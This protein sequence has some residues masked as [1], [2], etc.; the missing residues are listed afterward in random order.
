MLF[1]CLFLLCRYVYMG[2][3]FDYPELYWAW[4]ASIIGPITYVMALLHA[5]MWRR[6]SAVIGSAVSTCKLHFITL[7]LQHCFS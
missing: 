6:A 4:A 3:I 2:T 1:L 7:Q 5:V